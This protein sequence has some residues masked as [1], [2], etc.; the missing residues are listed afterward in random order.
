MELRVD[1][2]AG[3]RLD[4]W[5]AAKLPELSRSRIQELIREQFILRNGEPAKP[6][7]A[8]AAGDRLSVAIPEAVP[9]EAQP[10]DIPVKIL[11]EDEHVVVLDKDSGMVVHPAAGNPD[12]TLVNAL[13]H[14][15]KGRL[16]GIGGVERPGIVH[17]LDKDTSGCMVVAKTDVAHHSLTEQ[18][19]G[20]TMEKLYLAVVQGVPTPATDTVFTHIG[21]HPVNRQKMAVVNPP[22]GKTAITDYE[23]LAIDRASNSTLVLCH[24]HTGRTHQIRVHMLHKGC[25]LIGDP[26][27]ARPERQTAKPGRLM[28][29][30]WRLSFD[31]PVSGERLKFQAE[32]PPEYTPW[33][34]AMDGDL[35]G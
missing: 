12:G 4:A 8:V 2:N 31:H 11:F 15:C 32:V 23:I 1:G 22:G 21:R 9:A 3:M 29:H 13:L 20:R 19:S 10:Q 27:Y 17:R 33:I 35:P 16:S 5:L 26:I 30:A 6:R 24:L 25:P 28:L 7:D 14:H 18:F 34:L